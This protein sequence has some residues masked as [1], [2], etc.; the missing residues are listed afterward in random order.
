M[1]KFIIGSVLTIAVIYIAGLYPH[2]AV[3]LTALGIVII[4]KLHEWFSE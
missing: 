1:V 3:G 2:V 4:F